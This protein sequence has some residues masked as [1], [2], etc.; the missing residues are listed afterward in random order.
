M[1]YEYVETITK[2]NIKLFGCLSRKNN[3][4]CILYIPGLAGNFFESKF[5]RY[6]TQ[7]SIENGYDFLFSHNQGSF[8]VIE[9]PYLN[10][11]GKFKSI[12]KGAAYEKFEDSLCDIDSWVQYLDNL[13][14]K[15]IIL[16]CHS[17]GCNKVIYYL[18]KINNSKISI[19]I[20]LAPQDN[21]N[22]SKLDIHKGLFE[23]ANINIKNGYPD[24][25]LSKKFLG[26]CLM[27]SETYFQEI[28]NK[29]INNI[30]YKSNNGD[31][32]ALNSIK[33]EMYIII[34]SKDV[35]ENGDDYMK[36][37]VKNCYN[38]KYDIIFDANHNFKN[39][40]SQLAKLIIDYL[41]NHS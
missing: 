3:D 5:T 40:E 37:I 23:E 16:L 34:G 2:Q 41:K 14:Y 21:V 11:E 35:G 36:K 30:P 8:Q 13:G 10:D 33:K 19:V 15:E 20:L 28:T 1:N 29:T 9:L 31:F 38:A 7:L 27:S 18:S 39:K 6:I 26:F 12:I 25:I 4:K 22:F 24:K 17:L 32:S